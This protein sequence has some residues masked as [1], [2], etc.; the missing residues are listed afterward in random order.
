MKINE[1]GC[2]SCIHKNVC[3][4]CSEFKESVKKLSDYFSDDEDTL[5]VTVECKF[6]ERISFHC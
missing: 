5:R 2:G 4:H 6:F 3:K 1:R